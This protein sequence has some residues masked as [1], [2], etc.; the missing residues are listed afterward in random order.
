M[1]VMNARGCTRQREFLRGARNAIAKKP[2]Y[3][4]KGGEQEH[5]EE[6]EGQE[7]G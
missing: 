2:E 4:L 1:L 7:E 5:G 6:E 3:S